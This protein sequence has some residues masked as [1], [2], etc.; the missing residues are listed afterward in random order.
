MFAMPDTIAPTISGVTASNI[1]E[2]SATVIW[3]T[4][5]PAT[6]QVEYGTSTSYGASSISDDNLLT[7]HSVTLSW[8]TS[9]TTYHFRVKPKDA[10]SNGAASDD[11]T[12]TT[13]SIMPER[14]ALIFGKHYPEPW[15]SPV[16]TSSN[17]VVAYFETT[18][19]LPAV[20]NSLLPLFLDV[21]AGDKLPLNAEIL[22]PSAQFWA[23]LLPS[24][25]Q[26]MLDIVEWYGMSAE[27]YLWLLWSFA[28]P[29]PR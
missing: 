19:E 18:G 12:F 6:S 1:S 9:S 26:I 16:L 4:S 5:E 20:P 7:S 15:G 22:T 23:R 11:Y 8:L 24:E 3:T 10:S 27:D 2:S 21:K 13:K 29:S 25:R 28:P 14:T 17:W